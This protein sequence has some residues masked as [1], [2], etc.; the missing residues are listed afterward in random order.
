[1]ITGQ[2]HNNETWSETF[3]LTSLQLSYYYGRNGRNREKPIFLYSKLECG[4]LDKSRLENALKKTVLSNDALRCAVLD[5]GTQR[6]RKPSDDIEISVAFSNL[7][8]LSASEA[9]ER[10]KE[11]THKICCTEIATGTYPMLYA[12]LTKMPGNRH[13]L[14]IYVDG[15][16]C[17][18]WTNNEIIAMLD[19]FYTYPETAAETGIPFEQYVR[20]SNEKKEK[21]NDIYFWEE[22]V[23]NF[24]EPIAMPMAD[25]YISSEHSIPIE[26]K[27]RLD[28]AAVSAIEKYAVDH[29]VS[30]RSIFLA[31][32][33]R[34]V[35][36]YS[37]N[38]EFIV[39][40]PQFLRLPEY[41]TVSGECSDYIL[42]PYRRKKGETFLCEIK[43]IDKEL[44][45]YFAHGSV[46]GSRITELYRETADMTELLA[47]P[48]VFSDLL[49]LPAYEL[50][51]FNRKDFCTHTSCVWADC[52]ISRIGKEILINIDSSENILRSDMI[53]RIAEQMKSALME[54]EKWEH[55]TALS[56]LPH[57]EKII[58]NL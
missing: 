14:H 8:A 17:D 31:L 39:N 57:D 41:E 48:I 15:L 44:Q 13:I 5:N 47:A 49:D 38:V 52:G 24:P 30:L 46:S 27:I 16:V 2:N 33:C 10:L 23:R 37:E 56:L 21:E 26:S 4:M 43:R 12:E 36:M 7:S 40:I 42:F 25:G 50:S 20:E 55:L 32:Y 3:P 6:I 58:V 9:E 29:D 35:S 54:I 53:E 51:T 28:A 18:A 11:I 1:M 19:R 45:I 22:T 34:C